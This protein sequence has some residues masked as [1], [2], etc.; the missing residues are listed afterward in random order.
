[1][2]FVLSTQGGKILASGTGTAAD[3]II[4]LAGAVNAIDDYEGYKAADRRSHHRR[5]PDVILMMDR[6]GDHGATDAELIANPAIALTPAGKN[7]ADHP[8]GRLYLLGFGP[9]TADA[10]ARPRDLLY[11]DALQGSGVTDVLH[12]SGR[13]GPQ[14]M[15]TAAVWAAPRSS[16]LAG[17]LLVD[18]GHLDDHRRL[19]GL[20]RQPSSEAGSAW[21]PKAIC[22]CC[23]ITPS[24]IISACRA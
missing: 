9:R 23:A 2:L 19:R 6:G 15:A 24:S 21:S 14:P 18:H 17:L 12:I 8:P 5:S 11:G 3:G 22:C 7:H 13:L 10:V 16:L 1:M 4:A 20:G